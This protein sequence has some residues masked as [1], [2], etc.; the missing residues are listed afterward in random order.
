M[1]KRIEKHRLLHVIPG[2]RWWSSWWSHWGSHRSIS[3]R[4]RR[5]FILW[6]SSLV[7]GHR[8]N[9]SFIDILHIKLIY[10][11]RWSQWWSAKRS[12]Y[13]S[14]IVFVSWYF[15]PLVALCVALGLELV[16]ILLLKKNFPKAAYVRI[17]IEAIEPCI[18]LEPIHLSEKISSL[19][20]CPQDELGLRLLHL[21]HHL[22]HCLSPLRLSRWTNRGIHGLCEVVKASTT[23]RISELPCKW[24]KI[25][26]RNTCMGRRNRR[27][28][29]ND[30]RNIFA[31]IIGL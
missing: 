2:G 19:L 29:T 3:F 17:N 28:C 13:T 22:M 9:V 15:K 11:T 25:C 24:S 6:W 8:R 26:F 23:H 10:R 14:S 20:L 30:R 7:L 1:T 18:V 12:K 16:L 21:D 31:S 27:T 4:R 5:S